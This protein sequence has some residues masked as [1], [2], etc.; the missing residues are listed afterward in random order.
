MIRL[1]VTDV[2]E[3]IVKEGS[4]ELNTEYFDIIRRLQE[5]GIVFV[6]ASGRHIS[7]LEVAFA[8]VKEDIWFLSQNGS[9][10]KKG[11]QIIAPHPVPYEW[12][13]EFWQE[14]QEIQAPGGIAYDPE[15][16]NIPFRDDSLCQRL[17]QEYHCQVRV[18]EGWNPPS[19]DTIYT[20]ITL[21]HPE[22]A[23]Q[24]AAL[25][26]NREWQ[27]RLQVLT[28]GKNWVDLVPFGNGKGPALERLCQELHI[29][30]SQVMAFGDNMNDLSMIQFAGVGIAVDNA[31]PAVKAAAC[32][33]I[34]DYTK[35]GVLQELKGLLESL[36]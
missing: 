27:N 29:A 16:C 33:V 21:Y 15:Y 35:N 6:A 31:K 4:T 1:V 34:P 17:T 30:P 9:L 32:R 18:T 22:D 26:L 8:P 25:H 20:M 28:A 2:D 13:R 14:L 7:S 12:V 10:V 3:T 5:K 36:D 23:E 24:F 11:D 19:P